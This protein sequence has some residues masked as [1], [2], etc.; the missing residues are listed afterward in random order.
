M[1]IINRN[2]HLSEFFNITYQER[3]REMATRSLSNQ[4]KQ[5]RQGANSIPHGIDKS[6]AS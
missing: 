6:D 2:V 1:S 5:L 4:L 3:L